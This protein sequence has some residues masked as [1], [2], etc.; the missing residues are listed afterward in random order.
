MKIN[1]LNS[2]KEL[3]NEG[4]SCRNAKEKKGQKYLADREG[5]RNLLH[6]LWTDRL[7]K[8]TKLD[9]NAV[10]STTAHAIYKTDKCFNSVYG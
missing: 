4:G 9:Q 1:E 3:L 7:T 5:L 8:I 6:L 10:H 2:N